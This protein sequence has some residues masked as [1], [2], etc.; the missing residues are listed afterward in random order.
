[1]VLRIC[2]NKMLKFLQLSTRQLCFSFIIC[3]SVEVKAQNCVAK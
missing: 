1:M 3:S 2:P